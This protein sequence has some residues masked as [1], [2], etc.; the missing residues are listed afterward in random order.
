MINRLTRGALLL[1]LTFVATSVVA[2]DASSRLDQIQ[3]QAQAGQAIAQT[4]LGLRYLYGKDVVQDFAQAANWFNAAATQGSAEGQNQLARLYF[5]GLGVSQDSAE[6]LALFEQA[7]TSG[8]PTHLADLARVL[9][10]DPKTVARAA[11][12][13]TRAADAGH[14]E[15]IVS[16]GILYQSGRGVA[17]DFERA[18][19]LYST[20]AT[21]G[22]G[23]A[24]NNLGLMYVRGEGIE[25]DYTSA[26]VLFE[27]AAKLGV[28]QAFRNLGVLYE[29]GYGVP[30]NE[31]KAIALYKQAGQSRV[32]APLT[33]YVYDPRLLPLSATPEAL[34]VLEAT[35]A[36]GDPIAQFQFAW[37]LLQKPQV[38]AVTL[39]RAA[40]LFER[41]ARA[42]YGPAMANLGMMYFRGEGLLQDYVLGHMWMSSAV[43]SGVTVDPALAAEFAALP[44]AP[45]INE[46]QSMMRERLTQ[47]QP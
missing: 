9:E 41:A 21:A 22:N 31:E 16:L 10:T 44:T 19:N 26:A 45:Q 30:L 5:D 43:V 12:L 17:Q 39:R 1:L 4:D 34:Q 27:S 11:A 6:A 38:P 7:A 42:G 3:S 36:V 40:G 20:A 46:S 33:R 29:N 37:A 24:M 14:I 25:Q 2:Q 23:R 47:R 28:K 15:A 8:Q 35:A 18:R 32:P 13:Y